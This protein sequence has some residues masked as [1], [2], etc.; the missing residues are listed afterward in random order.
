MVMY[1]FLN[2]LK[3]LKKISGKH[4]VLALCTLGFF[5]IYALFSSKKSNIIVINRC[6]LRAPTENR[7]STDLED[8]L[9]ASVKP[10]PGR[11][12]FF[13][14]T[15]CHPPETHHI[16][17]LNARQAC[18]IESAAL[19]NPNFQVFVLFAGSTHLPNGNQSNPRN[20]RPLLDAIR[21]YK[22]V[23]LRQMNLW[24][25]TKNT[26]IED[27]FQKGDLFRSRFLTEHTA[28]F[29][30]LLSL[31]RYGGITLDL[32]MMVQRTLEFL[33][34]N[35]VGAHDNITLGNAVLSMTARDIGHKLAA[36]LLNDFQ[37]NYFPLNYVGNGPSL[38]TRQMRS[39]CNKATID[40]MIDDPQRCRGFKVF[41]SS[42]FYP[43]PL[44][45]WRHYIEPKFVDEILA[46]TKDAYI[47]HFWNR[48]AVIEQ[49]RLNDSA[50]GKLAQQH[51]PKTYV[52][53]GSY[54]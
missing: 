6:Y 2:I 37:R 13:H 27:W 1:I 14:E 5:L 33:P 21:S 42:A 36:S 29:V 52:A 26:P 28:D 24:E 32:D 25:Y 45:K 23:H 4:L 34:L 38:I 49:I 20:R 40:Q 15:A 18:S 12:I 39:L 19:H 11:A 46:M 7:N 47:I 51:C 17:N 8:V 44:L 43:I 22:N 30:R 16:L 50:Y 54:F 48:A 53:A 9:L 35:Y 3:R 41:N 31:Y 10:S